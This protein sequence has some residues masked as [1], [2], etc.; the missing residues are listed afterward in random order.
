M[1]TFYRLSIIFYCF[2]ITLLLLIIILLR[3]FKRKLLRYPN[4]FY[5]YSLWAQLIC[6]INMLA[7]LIILEFYAQTKNAQELFECFFFPSVFLYLIYFHYIYFLNIEIHTKLS[8][9]LNKCSKKRIIFY[10]TSVII[11]SLSITAIYY[12]IYQE[13]KNSK[14]LKKS[15]SSKTSKRIFNIMIYYLSF[16][17]FILCIFTS[18]LIRIRFWK[19]YK[20]LLSLVIAS[21]FI[22]VSTIAEGIVRTINL[23]DKDTKSYY[24]KSQILLLSLNGIFQ[25]LAVLSNRGFRKTIK[26]LI[27]KWNIM[28]SKRISIN[29][30]YKN[31]SDIKEINI[32]LTSGLFSDLFDNITKLVIATK[33]LIK[34][35][36]STSL[37]YSSQ[38]L[39]LNIKKTT[40]TSSHIE[41]FS[42]KFNFPITEK[43]K[44]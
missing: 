16:L 7:L 44:S 37:Y 4:Q 20:S 40:F 42:S 1:D 8:Q 39:D 41:A 34:I 22:S 6:G 23:Q 10:H 5:Y 24:T 15:N 35:L 30:S 26:K 36:V 43:S 17:S 25:G 32:S 11:I 38:P 28:N 27:E 21:T 29:Q 3:L 31:E 2:S 19:N 14:N 12:S 18:Y 13:E 33:T 9:S